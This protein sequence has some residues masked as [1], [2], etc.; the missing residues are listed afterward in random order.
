MLFRDT[1]HDDRKLGIQR[2]VTTL[3]NPIHEDH[4]TSA[5]GGGQQAFSSVEHA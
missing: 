3:A 5:G 4:Y 2:N 1:C